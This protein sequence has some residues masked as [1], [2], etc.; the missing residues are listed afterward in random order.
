MNSTQT[1]TKAQESR[2]V[3]DLRVF[4]VGGAGAHVVANLQVQD[5]VGVTFGICDTDA[6]ALARSSIETQV[7]LGTPHTRGLGTGGDPQV[8]RTAV[9]AS[10]GDL[11]PLFRGADLVFLVGGLGGGTASGAMPTLAEMAHAGGALVISLVFLP[12]AFEGLRRSQQASR[13][14]AQ[15]RAASDGV[16]CLSNQTL[17]EMAGANAP[18]QEVFHSANAL[19]A[20]GVHG[21]WRMLTVPGLLNADL[22]SL[23]TVL[24]GQHIQAVFSCAQAKGDNRADAAVEDLLRSPLL[25]QGSA[26][27]KARSC[28]VSLVGGTQLSIGEIQTALDRLTR[29][30]PSAHW[31]VGATADA[32]M[33]DE[34]SITLIAAQAVDPAKEAG[35]EPASDPEAEHEPEAFSPRQRAIQPGEVEAAFFHAQ[36]QLRP[37]SRFVAPPPNLSPEE[38]QRLFQQQQNPRRGGKHRSRW[39]QGVLPLEVASRGRFE[40]SEPTIHQGEDLDVPTF[41]RRGVVLN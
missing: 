25:D 5:L 34:L 17:L 30:A 12:F 10:R 7:D 22:G 2:H 8:A 23:R 6:A 19:L 38:K 33:A 35:S 20:E 27:A 37:P 9:E 28:L 29:Q 31:V 14:L 21:I 32:A 1:L 26:M 11:E 16:V 24:R 39:Q 18:A 40:K 15:L 13:A 36:P 3:H 4:G 41:V